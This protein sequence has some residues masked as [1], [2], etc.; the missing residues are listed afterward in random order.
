LYDV[1]QYRLHCFVST[2]RH[3]VHLKVDITHLASSVF[4]V[5]K[6]FLLHHERLVT[7]KE[8]HLSLVIDA[9][10]KEN[11]RLLTSIKFEY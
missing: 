7:L 11:N 10:F 9:M 2:V 3:F 6:V 1:T 4:F 8:T 5:I